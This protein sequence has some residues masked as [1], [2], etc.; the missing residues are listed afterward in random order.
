MDRA[1]TLL[2][3]QRQIFSV[4]GNIAKS[5]SLYL[6]DD[7]KLSDKDFV[8]DF[9]KV[10]FNAMKNIIVGNSNINEINSI[11]IDNFLKPYPRYYNIWSENNGVDYLEDARETAQ[12]EMYHH[13]YDVVKKYSLL[14][15]YKDI[16]IDIKDLYD[17]DGDTSKVT[18]DASSIDEMS[19]DDILEH[20]TSKVIDI[21]N[22]VNENSGEI[23]K[24]DIND[25]IDNLFERLSLRPEMGYPFVNEYYNG[26]FRGMRPGKYMLRS[27]DTGTGK[28]RQDIIDMCNVACDEK[29]EIGR[30]WVNTGKAYDILF[31]STELNKQEL[32]VLTLAYLTG[33]STSDIESGQYNEENRAK[34]E[35]GVEVIKRSKMHFVFIADF[36][37]SDI[38]LLIE[39]H[40]LK[41]EIQYVVF[42]YIQNS[43]KLSRTLQEGFG[44]TLREDEIVQTFSKKLK[45]LAEK[46]SLFII[47]S[48]Q[49]NGKAKDES[50]FVSKDA[51][52][53]RG[54]RATA[55]KVDYGI[56]TFRAT[57]ADWKQLE[58][59]ITGMPGFGDKKPDF[60]HWVYKNR[61]GLDHIVVWTQMDLGTMRENPLFITD[62]NYDLV[63]DVQRIAGDIIDDDEEVEDVVEEEADF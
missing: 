15:Q 3:P 55:D 13:D 48:T 32:Q 54:G 31:I 19:I 5:P 51:N 50:V 6:K 46:Y 10:L 22:D 44:H 2:N 28:T 36:S 57:P 63:T 4:M 60:A 12:N 43:Q 35:H 47:S 59:V 23:V 7:N 26:L 1:D 62:Y 45:E 53:L 37:I 11:T 61:A 29:Y 27:G 25:D 49:L 30:G 38:Q 18:N 16:G 9:H 41:Y 52:V 40:V 21:R 17:Y 39:E 24:F 34:L 14:R 56:L 20:Y 58:T 8:T 42:D 33:I